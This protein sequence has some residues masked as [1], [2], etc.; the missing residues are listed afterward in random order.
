MP[1]L[2][3][4]IISGDVYHHH[5]EYLRVNRAFELWQWRAD[6]EVVLELG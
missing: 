4:R 2:F 5:L 3:E 1:T 6:R